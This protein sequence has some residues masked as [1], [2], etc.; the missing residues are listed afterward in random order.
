[1][2]VC[3]QK[4]C[5]WLRV[6]P[7]TLLIPKRPHHCALLLL[8]SRSRLSLEHRGYKRQVILS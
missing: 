5:V 1:M 3:G 4:A 6:L 7:F 2:C 8:D